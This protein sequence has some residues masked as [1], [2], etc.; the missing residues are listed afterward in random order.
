MG[1]RNQDNAWSWLCIPGEQRIGT[2]SVTPI[3]YQFDK[4]GRVEGY[5]ISG[6]TRRRQD[7]PL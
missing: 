2:L 6:L 7:A 3:D 4:G 5:D 1:G